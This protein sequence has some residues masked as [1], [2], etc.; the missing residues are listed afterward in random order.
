MEILF[1]AVERGPMRGEEIINKARKAK[2]DFG[3]VCPKKFAGS[4]AVE[5]LRAALND[6]GI[7]TSPRDV[8]VRGIPLEVDLIIPFKNQKPIL[9]L[10]YE[11]KQVAVALE[12]KKSGTFGESALEKIRSDFAQL[13]EAGINCAY[14]TFEERKNYRWRATNENLGF[15]CYTLAWHVKTD[16]P[17]ELTQD[18]DRFVIFLRKV[19]TE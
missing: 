9:G 14:I 11:P 17:L 5:I 1:K 2:D 4:V 19:V 3:N 10:L 18:W 16:G 7:F 8:F 6:E 15:P 13:Q 12:V